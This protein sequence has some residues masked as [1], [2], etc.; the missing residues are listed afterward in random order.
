MAKKPTGTKAPEKTKKKLKFKY[1]FDDAYN[2]VYANGA[3]VAASSY[4]EFVIHF[5]HERP[6]V[7]NSVTHEVGR[8]NTLG[9]EIEREPKDH[10][11]MLVRY[12]ATGVAMSY[13]EA[14]RFHEWLGEKIEN[15]EETSGIAKLL[16]KE[17]EE[18]GKKAG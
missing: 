7:P 9:D 13:V 16:K 12:V 5:Y 1:I 3:L 2:P 17:G 6:P 11:D 14:K 4:G 18:N 8:G 10:K 15:F